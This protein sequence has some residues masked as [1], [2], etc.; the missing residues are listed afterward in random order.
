MSDKI[1]KSLVCGYICAIVLCGA[2]ACQGAGAAQPKVVVIFVDASASIKDVEIYRDAWRKILDRV[3]ADDRVIL[4]RISDETLTQFRPL[5]DEILPVYR[6]WSDNKLRYEKKL[7]ASRQKLSNAL[8]D[9]LKGGKS[10]KTDILNSLLLAEKVFQGEKRLPVLVLLSDMLEDSDKYKFER[11]KITDVFIR[12]AIE[13]KRKNKELP[14][15]LK[16]KVYVAGAS[17]KT[18]GKALEVQRFWLEY[19]KAANATIPPQNY[20]PALI[21][22]DE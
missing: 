8:D 3:N 6:F 15:L 19:L 22:F 7:K 14:D 1:L 12:Q 13:E 4:G 10:Q 21:N 9:A 5:A 16:A 20:G 18:S 11:L 2:T 17:A